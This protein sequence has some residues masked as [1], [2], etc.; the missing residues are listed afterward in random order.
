MI[1]FDG[2][3]DL[4]V[5]RLAASLHQPRR[6]HE[7]SS[8]A[9]SVAAGSLRPVQPVRLR[10]RQLHGA[11]VDDLRQLRSA[12]EF[13]AKHQLNYM[14]DIVR[15]LHYT[16]KRFN[17][18]DVMVMALDQGVIEEQVNAARPPWLAMPEISTQRRLNFEMSVKNLYQS[19]G[20]IATACRRSRAC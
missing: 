2:K 11:G 13:F 19:F 20:K 12:D 9:E 4:G 1:I 14:G 17:F 16:G 3:G 18:Y 8:A 10:R 15:I 7:R 5:L 6:T